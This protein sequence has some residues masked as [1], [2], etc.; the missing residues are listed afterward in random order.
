MLPYPVQKGFN[1]FKNVLLSVIFF[2][3]RLLPYSLFDFV[4]KYTFFCFRQFYFK[5]IYCETSPTLDCF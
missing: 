3:P 1:V 4:V 2:T 5:D